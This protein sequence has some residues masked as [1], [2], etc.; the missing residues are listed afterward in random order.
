MP[1]PNVT[2]Y[3]HMGHAMFVA[4][5]DILARFHRM[6]RRPTL[7]LP[8]TDHAGIATQLLVERALIAEGTSREELGRAAF[9]A[10]VW[11]WKAEKGGYIMNQMRRLGASADWSRERFTLEPDMSDAVVE[12]FVRLHGSGLVYKGTRMVNWSPNLQTAVSDLEVEY[13]DETGKLYQFKYP[14]VPLEGGEGAEE[15]EEFVEVATTRPETILG[16]TGV[17]V[18]PDDARFKHLIGREVRCGSDATCDG[19]S[20]FVVERKG[21]GIRTR[22]RGVTR[23][24]DDVRR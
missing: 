24:N 4:I 19:H 21:R 10:R 7:W 11:E 9:E 23:S 15:E 1:P 14:L 18:H 12:A 3:L 8:G 17:A 6:R 22:R 20:G 2:G 13:N 5:Q 16:D